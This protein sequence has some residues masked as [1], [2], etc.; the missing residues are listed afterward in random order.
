MMYGQT[1]GSASFAAA[2]LHRKKCVVSILCTD[3]VESVFNKAGCKEI[4]IYWPTVVRNARVQQGDWHCDAL[5]GK[6]MIKHLKIY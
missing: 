1:E 3:S 6:N 4:N 2:L 5:L